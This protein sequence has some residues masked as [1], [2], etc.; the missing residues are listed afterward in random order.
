MVASTIRLTGQLCSWEL[1]EL[2]FSIQSIVCEG[3][4]TGCEEEKRCMYT[5]V[6]NQKVYGVCVE[7]EM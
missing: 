6:R 7:E 5:F 3:W 4:G 1:S 2:V